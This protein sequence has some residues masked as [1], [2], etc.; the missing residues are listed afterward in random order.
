M[1]LHSYPVRLNCPC[2]L[3]YSYLPKGSKEYSSG[4]KDKRVRDRWQWRNGDSQHKLEVNFKISGPVLPLISHLT[5]VKL[6]PLQ[7]SSIK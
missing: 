3:E 7:A 4:N 2:F 1:T 6:Q 5:L